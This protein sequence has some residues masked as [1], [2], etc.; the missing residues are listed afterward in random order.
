MKNE[1]NIDN[2]FREKLENFSVQPPSQIWDN[3]QTQLAVQKRKNRMIIIGWISAAAVIVLAFVAGWYLN[4]NLKTEKITS[5]NKEIIQPEKT[6]KTEFPAQPEKQEQNLTAQNINENIEKPA[7]KTL[8]TEQVKNKK[9]VTKGTNE[10]INAREDFL[11]VR[12][13][14]INAE[15]AGRK[16]PNN[17]LAFRSERIPDNYLTESEQV[18]VAQNVKNMKETTKPDNKW[19]MGM[20]VSPGYSSQVASHSENYS[21]NM[22]YSGSDGNSNVGGGFSVQYKTSKRWIVESGVYYAQNG[23][24]SNNTVNLF[25]KNMDS[26]A[27]FAPGDITYL[28]NTVKLENNNLTMNSTA[29]VIQF[30]ETPKGAELSG[31]F[32]AS[33]TNNVNLLVPNGEFSQVFDFMEIPLFVRYRVIDSKFGVELITGLNAGIVVGNNA[34][35]ENQYGLQNIGET[36]DI[37]PVNLS[38]T[39]GIGVNYALGKHVYLAFEPRFNYYLSSINS[40]PSVDFR[41]YRLGFFTGV[42]YEF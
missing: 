25:S 32:E 10:I 14:S 33:K 15:V 38:G 35:I 37:S 31:D 3:V 6:E 30:N 21:E 8:F 27:S 24:Q 26:E 11:I 22:T 23:Q 40:N 28:N 34:Y 41:P 36:Q 9:T 17:E 18:L 29:G 7:K 12:I 20:Y 19:K 13:E 39:V 5:V 42:S 1:K 16:F 2:I 4:D